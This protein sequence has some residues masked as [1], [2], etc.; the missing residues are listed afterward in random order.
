MR[1]TAIALV[2]AVLVTAACTEDEP[3][4]ATTAS[5]TPVTA[6]ASTDPAGTTPGGTGSPTTVPSDGSIVSAYA[7]RPWFAGEVPPAGVAADASLPPI[8]VGMINQENSPIG[9]FPEIR[10]AVQAAVNWIN[11]E[12][13]G[14]NG[15]PIELVPCITSF[16][17][18][19]SQA[20]A[21]QLVQRGAVAVINGLDITSNGSLP[22]LEQNGIPLVSSLP[23]TL[24]ELRSPDVVSFSGSV[25]GAYVAFVSHA[26]AQGAKKIAIAYGQFDSF[27]VPATQY[28]KPVAERLGLEV[29]LVPFSLGTTDFLP[30]VQ[31]AIDSGADAVTVAAADSSCVPIITTL[32]DLGYDGQLYMVGACAAREILAQLPDDVQ[33]GV[34]FNSEGPA[35]TSIEAQMYL[36]AI[37]RYVTEPAGGAGTVSFRA[38]MNLWAALVAVDAAGDVTPAA[39]RAHFAAAVGAPSYWGHPYTCDGRQVPGFP[40]L[41]SPQQTLFRALN[42]EGGT[43]P[44]VDDWIDVPAFVAGL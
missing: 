32:H 7:G 20:C 1:T 33:S 13:G 16:S 31:A 2:A 34:I 14:V 8:V 9:S 44:V 25:T 11:A 23:T 36:A 17:V 27:E 5:T 19:Q 40:A 35:G 15:R 10:A 42:D 3:P 41:C 4:A 21:Q 6:P 38:A 22:I 28:A 30:V 37:D 39:L 43:D 26:A 29:A 12:L 24:S 18:E